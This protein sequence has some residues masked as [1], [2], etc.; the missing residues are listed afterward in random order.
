[1]APVDAYG[2]PIAAPPPVPA[3]AA[4]AGQPLINVIQLRTAFGNLKADIPLS[5]S[6][7]SLV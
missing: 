4:A 3:Q 2:N 1:M 6:S 5:R 7:V